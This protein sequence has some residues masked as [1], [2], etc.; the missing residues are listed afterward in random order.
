MLYEMLAGQP[1]FTGPTP[2][3]IVHQHLTAEP[4]PVTTI[5]P[6]TSPALAAA[7]TRAL[8]KTPADRFP[9]ATAFAKAARQAADPGHAQ[10]VVDSSAVTAAVSRS[11]SPLRHAGARRPRAWRA[12]SVV[13][14]IAVLAVAAWR[15]RDPL[16]D[17]LT[18]HHLTPGATKQ[19]VLV[20][21]FEST[22]HDA[23]V[24][25]A[26]RNL[27]E[28]ALSQSSV[29]APVSREQ[30]GVALERS[31]RAD[32]TRITRQLARE[33]AYRSSIK[34]VVAG[35]VQRI[36]GTFAVTLHAVD[37]DTGKVSISLDDRAANDAAFIPCMQRLGGRLRRALGERP[38]AIRATRPLYE[39][40]TPS[41]E[42]YREIVTAEEES[43]RGIISHAQYLAHC[44]R[45]LA[46][47][48]DCSFAWWE[49]LERPAYSRT[50][51]SRSRS[52][53]RLVA[54]EM[55]ATWARRAALRRA[56]RELRR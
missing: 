25:K 12:W 46:L 21:D 24:E 49:W 30:I 33:L 20:A 9:S 23:A 39:V 37:A 56:G 40:L 17:L 44:R 14:G 3:S 29:L 6:S 13:A 52:H 45:A 47:D 19:W 54:A 42:A 22:P 4:R 15:A 7:L 28:V 51:G 1:P 55:R 43:R 32:T 27:V 5:R 50:A 8:A 48:P 34:T 2:Q 53:E 18:G 35:D 31:G 26:A 16:E 41:F 10:A 11:A 36:G 38:S